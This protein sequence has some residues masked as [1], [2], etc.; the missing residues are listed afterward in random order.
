MPYKKY[1]I[2]FPL[3]PQ[4]Q[5]L[6]LGVGYMCKRLIWKF[7]HTLVA[8]LS[9]FNR[10]K[11]EMNTHTSAENVKSTIPHI[12]TEQKFAKGRST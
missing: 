1:W 2:S 5:N 11:K 9:L 12:T 4:L 3:P 8:V 6:V 7:P 10:R